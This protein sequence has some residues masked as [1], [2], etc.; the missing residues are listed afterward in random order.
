VSGATSTL[1]TLPLTLNE[2]MT[3][4]PNDRKWSL[5]REH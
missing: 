2:I 5:I 4:P 3:P 1:W